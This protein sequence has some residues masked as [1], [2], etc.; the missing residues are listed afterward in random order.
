MA[1]LLFREVISSMDNVDDLKYGFLWIKISWYFV[2]VLENY[3]VIPNSKYFLFSERYQDLYL[4]GCMDSVVCPCA[5]SVHVHH[6][7]LCGCAWLCTCCWRGCPLSA[8]SWCRVW[9]SLFILSR[10]S[11]ARVLLKEVSFSID[12]VAYLKHGFLWIR[13]SWYFLVALENYM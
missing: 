2:V 1:R 7:H 8:H 5:I 10:V 11:M 13:T 12:I 9:M 6:I 4:Q 3:M